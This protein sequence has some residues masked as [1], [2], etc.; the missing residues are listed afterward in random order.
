MHD[1][2]LAEVLI[3]FFEFS[4]NKK[5]R[6][7]QKGKFE[8][9]IFN[10]ISNIFRLDYFLVKY[11]LTLALSIIKMQLLRFVIVQNTQTIRCSIMQ[12]FWPLKDSNIMNCDERGLKQLQIKIKE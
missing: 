8:R 6:E 9:K 4:M 7:N 5:L 12:Q 11:L 2:C 3:T 10:F 1:Y